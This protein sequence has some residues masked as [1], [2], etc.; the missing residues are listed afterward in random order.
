MRCLHPLVFSNSIIRGN[1]VAAWTGGGTF[2]A[3]SQGHV[4]NCL[5]YNNHSDTLNNGAT[6]GGLGVSGKAKVD[7]INS[8]FTGNSAGR[9]GGIQVYRGGEAI[10]TNSI[11]WENEPQQL[12]LSAVLDT[13]PCRLTLNYN[14]IQ[15][16]LDSIEVT[17]TVSSIIFGVGNLDKAPQFANEDLADFHL[18]ETSPLIGAATDSL[19]IEGTWY[20][21]PESDLDGNP[22]PA[23]TGSQPDMGAYENDRDWPVGIQ[24]ATLE[25]FNTITVNPFPNPFRNSVI[26][27][28]QLPEESEVNMEV[29]NLSGRLV[30]VSGSVSLPAGTSRIT[31][32]APSEENQLYFYR[33]RIESFSGSNVIRT[34]KIIRIK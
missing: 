15:F 3:E 30:D 33:I 24:A 28:L 5:F 11:F 22:R 21:I 17:D 19:E 6:S 20:L 29:F 7:V 23:P 1:R 8:T 31:W 9:G 34:G 18:L 12:A 4:F 13:L 2:N 27:E 10:V 25:D 14:D 26:L 16:G 32:S